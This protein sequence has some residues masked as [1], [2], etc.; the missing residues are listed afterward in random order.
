LKSKINIGAVLLLLIYIIGNSLFL[1]FHNHTPPATISYEKSNLCEKSIY[2][3][4]SKLKC[5][6]KSHISV[7][8]KKCLLCDNHFTLTYVFN[9]N[10]FYFIALLVGILIFG[11]TGNVSANSILKLNNKGPPFAFISVF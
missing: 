5:E 4:F 9:L 3:S 6:H 8:H 1:V 7:T 2:Y 10:S 11:Y